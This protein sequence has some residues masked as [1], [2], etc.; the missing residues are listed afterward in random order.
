MKILQCG[1]TAQD[2]LPTHKNGIRLDLLTVARSGVYRCLLSTSSN[3]RRRMKPRARE[4]SRGH[5]PAST[6]SSIDSSD[7]DIIHVLSNYTPTLVLSTSP[8]RWSPQACR[9]FCAR[10]ESPYTP[11]ATPCCLSVQRAQPQHGRA[12]VTTTT[13]CDEYQAGHNSISPHPSL[14][15]QS[16]KK[17]AT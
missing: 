16:M 4:L 11:Q 7:K 3:M 14:D 5:Q 12:W 2:L 6:T 13:G 1:W 17:Y 15:L 10:Y 8:D 9:H